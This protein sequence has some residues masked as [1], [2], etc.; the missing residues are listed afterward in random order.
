MINEVRICRKLNLTNQ[1]NLMTPRPSRLAAF[2]L[3]L[4]FS[5]VGQAAEPLRFERIVIDGHFPGGYQV[6]V[7]DVNN[8]KKPDIVALGGSTLVWYENPSWA[9]RVVSAGK[10][11]HDIISSATADL[12]GDGKSEIAIAHDFSMNEPSRGKLLLAIQGVKPDDPWTFKPIAGVP[13]IHRLRWG[14]INGDGRLDLV[15]API[16]GAKSKP[17]DF[18]QDLAQLA[19][20]DTGTDPKTGDW[21]PLFRIGKQVLHAIEVRPLPDLPD[22]ASILTAERSGVH[23]VD[24][25]SGQTLFV[26][27][28]DLIPG[29]RGAGLNLGSSEV[30][31]GKLADGR[32]FLATIDPWHGS[33]VAVCIAATPNRIEKFG[34][35]TVLDNT[36]DTGHALW[37][38]DVDGDG[39]DEVFAGHRGKGARVSVYRFD[40]KTWTRTVIDDRLTAQDLR[41]GDIDG[42]G[43]PDVVAIGGQSHNIVWFKPIRGAER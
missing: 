29:A 25:T 15:V 7:V 11:T 20:Y 14:D 32:A 31:L 4:L 21:R 37:V 42:D 6:E 24:I 13:S 34:P 2:L 18:T 19:V 43:T 33:D 27:T 12:D 5:I 30:H 22:R 16:F 17:P 9:K 10:T 1:D 23:R 35:R 28:T 38:A 41:G 8:D 3:V 26:K 39:N 36:L 40:G